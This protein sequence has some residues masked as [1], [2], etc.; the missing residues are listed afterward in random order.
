M[1]DNLSIAVNAFATHELMSVS[2]DEAL[3]PWLVN[4]S[5]SFSELTF[6]EMSTVWLKQYIPPCMH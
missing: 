6:S 4:L 2:I 5:T 3:L 1:T